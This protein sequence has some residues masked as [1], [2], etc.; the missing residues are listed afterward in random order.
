M[1]EQ[2]EIEFLAANRKKR[3]RFSLGAFVRICNIFIVNPRLN[4]KKEKNKQSGGLLS[5]LKAFFTKKFLYL[6]KMHG[7]N[8]VFYY[9]FI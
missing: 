3:H 5:F 6:S 7:L 1:L 8:P 9:C 2:R 4:V